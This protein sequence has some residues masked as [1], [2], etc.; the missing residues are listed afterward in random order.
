[1]QYQALSGTLATKYDAWLSSL[2]WQSAI[3]LTF[4]HYPQQEAQ[5]QHK[6]PGGRP[7]AEPTGRRPGGSLSARSQYTE[8]ELHGLIYR[9]LFRPFERQFRTHIAAFGVLICHDGNTHLHALAY[10]AGD[11]CDLAS[12][13]T[14]DPAFPLRNQGLYAHR[15]HSLLF[16]PPGLYMRPYKGQVDCVRAYLAEN[17]YDDTQGLNNVLTWG[18]WRLL[19]DLKQAVAA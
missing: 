6:P 3:T 9:G 8:S 7:Q 4:D 11:K 1:M 16:R 10:A 18:R 17:L 5:H 2:P 19:R 15:R 13:D 12:I 14:R